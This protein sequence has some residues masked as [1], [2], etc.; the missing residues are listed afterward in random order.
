[1]RD[2]ESFESREFADSL[3]TVARRFKDWEGSPFHAAHNPKLLRMVF[4]SKLRDEVLRAGLDAGGLER[5]FWWVNQGRTYEQARAA[6]SFGPQKRTQPAR[7][8]FTGKI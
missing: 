2:S 1:M 3:T 7:R 5:R 8:H 6:D 4:D